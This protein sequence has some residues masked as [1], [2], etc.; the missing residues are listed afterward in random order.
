[1]SLPAME[2]DRTLL[3]QV[4]RNLLTNALK[5]TTSGSVRLSARLTGQV[6]IEFSVSDTGI[7]VAPEDCDRIFEE[8]YQ[9]RGPMQVDFKGTGLGLPYARRVAQALGGR[10][11]LES[12]LG[13]GSTFTVT[14]PTKWQ[15]LLNTGQSPARRDSGGIR[16]GTVLVVDDDEGFRT[17]VRGLLQGVAAQVLEA[18]DGVEGL[19]MMRSAKPDIVFMDLKMPNM[20]GADVM[21][22]MADD[23][24]LRDIPVV[25]VTSN[26]LDAA[27]R[28]VLGAAV[29]LLAK[30]GVTRESLAGA[31]EKALSA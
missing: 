8:F 17:V 4:L 11:S 30:S 5:F 21:G 31:V 9:V 15:A 22:A 24:P 28:P 1:V 27:N 18:R 14:L 25:I 26:E 23:P 3:A 29:A 19:A 20:D 7:G 2:T 12:E 13:L 6:E 16:V 10:L